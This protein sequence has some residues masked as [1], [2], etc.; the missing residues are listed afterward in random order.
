MLL[1][2]QLLQVTAWEHASECPCLTNSSSEWHALQEK[3]V[4]AGFPS[5]YGLEGCQ[6][7]DHGYDL[8]HGCNESS[9]HPCKVEC[10][11]SGHDY[12][13]SRWCY[14]DVARCR[15]NEQQCSSMG[16]TKGSLSHPSCRTREMSLSNVILNS[17]THYSYQTCGYLNTY[18]DAHRRSMNI[19]IKVSTRKRGGYTIKLEN[20]QIDPLRPELKGYQGAMLEFFYDTVMGNFDPKPQIV[21][22]DSWATET[23]KEAIQGQLGVKSSYT[24]CVHD[25]AVGKYDLCI[26]PF[27]H[28]TLREAMTPFTP[29]LEQAYFYL[30][31]PSDPTGHDILDDL[32]RP[33]LPFQPEAWLAIFGFLFG[34]ALLRFIMSNMDGGE[35]TTQKSHRHQVVKYMYLSLD[36]FWRGGDFPV[37]SGASKVFLLGFTFFGVITM[38]SYTANLASLLVEEK[39]THKIQSIEDAIDAGVKICITDRIQIPLGILYPSATN[40][41]VVSDSSSDVPRRMH[42]GECGAGVLHHN[43]IADMYAG[44]QVEDN[45]KALDEEKLTAD[46]AQCLRTGDGQID[47]T[48]DCSLAQVGGVIMAMPIGWPVSPGIQR[49][50]AAAIVKEINSGLYIKKQKSYE[51]LKPVSVCH[52][53][54]STEHP[55]MPISALIGTVLISSSLMFIALAWTLLEA[56]GQRRRSSQEA[57]QEP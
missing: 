46:K 15:Y 9:S 29:A 4:A 18:E 57:T 38:A 52:A 22:D 42:L 43:H 40:L 56:I 48:R 25:V 51:H 14:V 7:Y 3:I 21:L 47:L 8:P 17:S 11:S 36:G 37:K 50:L 45:C 39:Q 27:L 20:G 10:T 13:Q 53:K 44:G 12:C 6:A 55:G 35:R 54:R 5:N 24:A 31:I 41:L 16:F 49:P 23:S 32:A 33:F 1:S 26:N 34:A 2:V 19:V 28:T 30:I